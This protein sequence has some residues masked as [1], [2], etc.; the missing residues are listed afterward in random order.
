MFVFVFVYTFIFTAIL[1]PSGV[2][3]HVNTLDRLSESLFLHF[4][5]YLYNL[6]FSSKHALS[7]SLVWLHLPC[8]IFCCLFVLNAFFNLV[9]EMSSDLSFCF[10]VSVLTCVAPLIYDETVLV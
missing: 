9:D 8:F 4:T 10:D 7:F 5:F 3:L 6:T 1:R 2:H